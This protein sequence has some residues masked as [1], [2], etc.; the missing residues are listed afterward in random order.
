MFVL[1]APDS[2]KYDFLKEEIGYRLSDRVLDIK[3]QMGTCV[4]L[5]SSK[6]Y[7]TRH[8]TG[9]SVKKIIATEMS[10]AMLDL[11]QMP[12]GEEVR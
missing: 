11:C 10:P 4:D 8:L 7:V 1:Q 12:E 2:E 6:G 9:H 3:R 5:G